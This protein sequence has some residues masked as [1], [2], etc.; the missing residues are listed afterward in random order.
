MQTGSIK[1]NK[2]TINSYFHLIESK[3]SSNRIVF[4]FAVLP[5]TSANTVILITLKHYKLII[6]W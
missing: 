4:C 6:W 5:I 3:L 1:I 2:Q